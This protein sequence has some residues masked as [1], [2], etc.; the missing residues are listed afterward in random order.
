MNLVKRIRKNQT[1]IIAVVVIFIFV[2]FVGEQFFAELSR[3]RTEK[4]RTIAYFADGRKITNRDIALARQELEILKLLQT[5][6]I[7]RSII[8]P[9][10]NTH[11]LQAILLSELLFSDRTGSPELI[12]YIK[13]MIGANRYRISE[14]QINDIYR[15]S[16]PSE[17]YWVLLKNEAQ[18]AGL[19][20]SNQM[21]GAQLARVIPQVFNGATYS[22]LMGAMVSRQG[23]SEDEMLAAFGKLMMVLAYA[24]MMCDSEDVTISQIMHSASW[25]EEAMDV[26]FVKFDSALFAKT[27]PEPSEEEIAGHFDKYKAFFAGDI[28]DQNPYGFGYKLDDRVQLEYIAVKLD[29]IAA[30]VTPPTQ[31]EAEEFYQRHREEF[32]ESFPSDPNNPD[33][34]PIERIKS[35][36]EMAGD[37]S[38]NLLQ[39]KINSQAEK[40][41]NDA[42]AITE[43]GLQAE[44]TESEKIGAE[45]YREMVGDYTAAA[46]Q[47]S[48]KYNIKVYSGQT[49]LLNAS[50][51]FK[52]EY[53]GMMF[54]K[55]YGYNPVALI[56]T[57]FAIDELAV[58]ELGPFDVPKP[59][60]YENIG[61]ATDM[62]GRI[63]AVVRATKAEK[64]SE[65]ENANQTFA[66]G[67][68]ELNENQE[69]PDE[70]VFSVRE[71]MVED[72]KKL[73]A[74]DVT[75]D[76]AEEFIN[77]AAKDGWDKA[78]DKFNMLYKL[79][80]TQ[81]GEDANAFELQN[82]T[83]IS[84][85]SELDL[86]MASLQTIGNPARRLAIG[87]TQKSK[88]LIDQLYSLIPQDSNTI[89]TLPLVM[90]FKPDM[91]YFCLKNISVKRLEQDQYDRIKAIQNYK[92]DFV[93]SQSL[94]PV[95]FNPDNI[96]KRMKF[97]IVE[98]QTVPQDANKPSES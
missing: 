14:K 93:Q 66:N 30:T 69:Q 43:A 26:E 59:R 84:R 29:E 46:K 61:P 20:V 2:G 75:R 71:K 68:L 60:L 41:F 40:V 72:L 73:A 38:K 39:N 11:D 6:N 7:L 3:R 5:D 87:N 88:Q 18:L 15:R 91:A 86:E 17:I 77:L 51:F 47:L 67:S 10:S 16:M 74:M 42:K 62:L 36:S 22:Q 92:E 65:P 57:V 58:S 70:K 1:K 19:G 56:R 45:Q 80:D 4:P 98:E 94:A 82:L 96:L 50:D 83:N 25:S 79:A 53:L 78:I 89:D 76:K 95:H 90:E 54:L 8:M 21:A 28:N 32:T 49:G 27:Q 9:M 44:D 33:S 97:K 31:E 35:Y 13:Q 37:I 24:R 81:N 85:I 52:D 23:V 55:G 48:E 12:S 34:Q 63:M 64:A